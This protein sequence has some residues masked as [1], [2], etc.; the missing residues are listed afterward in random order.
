MEVIVQLTFQMVSFALIMLHLLNRCTTF[1]L[2]CIVLFFSNGLQSGFQ[3]LFP[4]LVCVRQDCFSRSKLRITAAEQD[5]GCHVEWSVH[6]KAQLTFQHFAQTH[7][8]GPINKPSTLDSPF[9]LCLPSFIVTVKTKYQAILTAKLGRGRAHFNLH[10][11]NK[12]QPNQVHGKSTN[13]ICLLM[14]SQS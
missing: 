3:Q 14:L 13:S 8:Q 12:W 1:H 4:K 10:K 9:L 6:C 2:L 11:R 5:S 7:I